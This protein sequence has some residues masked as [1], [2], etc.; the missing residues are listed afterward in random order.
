MTVQRFRKKPVVVEAVQ[1]TGR[2]IGEIYDFTNKQFRSTASSG[3]LVFDELHDTWVT[4]HLGHWVIKGVKGEF[5][6]CDD[7]VLQKTYELV[8]EERTTVDKL[9]PLVYTVLVRD[10][11]GL[12]QELGVITIDLMENSIQQAKREFVAAFRAIADGVGR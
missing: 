7:E 6:P 11:Y 10:A 3:A 4:I 2:N 1:W 12:E 8:P 5:Y 9:S